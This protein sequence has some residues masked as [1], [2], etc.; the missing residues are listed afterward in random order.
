MYINPQTTFTVYT[1]VPFDREHRHILRFTSL[2]AQNSYFTG[3]V[4]KSYTNFTYVR[5]DREIRVPETAD[6]LVQGNY[7]S[8]LNAGFGN[9][10]FY[11]F[12]TNIEY[13][14]NKTT[15]IQ[16]E[17]DWVQT[18]I[19]EWTAGTCFVE[20]EHVSN[21]AVGA[22]TV[23]EGLEVGE[24]IVSKE[25]EY[26]TR[27]AIL[28]YITGDGRMVNSVYSG[29]SIFSA[30]DAPT[31]NGWLADYEET[32]EKVALVIMGTTDMASGVEPTP[33]SKSVTFPL[34]ARTFQFQGDSYVPKNNKLFTFP[35]CFLTVDNY[36]GNSET[37]R[38]EN[39]NTAATPASTV[40]F[41]FDQSPYPKPCMQFYPLDYNGV[42]DAQS[43]AVQYD[44]FPMCSYSMDTFRAWISQAVPQALVNT[45]ANVAVGIISGGVGGAAGAALGGVT[46]IVKSGADFA[47][48]YRQQKL[49]SQSLGGT[50]SSS[51]M[52]FY[53]GDIGFRVQEHRI[54]PEFAR[55]IDGYFT[56]FGYKVDRY[57]Q[58]NLSGHESFNY[59]KCIDA[60]CEG[61]VPQECIEQVE[62][63]LNSGVTIH[64]GDF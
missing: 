56:R 58:P 63:M 39:F 35:Y 13:S 6:D 62:G 45:G 5:Q 7:C 18:F 11:A 59:V 14:A 37:I 43:Q 31:M 41:Q 12:I 21:D 53:K 52:N 26:L 3:K 50:I 55:I 29:T 42:H 8:F 22:N 16:I 9:K 20:R 1:G 2:S 34:S 48:E 19:L 4:L 10:R 38:M 61:N 33:T 30:T 49:H 23:P 60:V 27:G 28:A 47:L 54:K 17:V 57:K 44:N 36:S 40:S 46:G 24:Y 15:R 25:I 64:H 32:P 51:G